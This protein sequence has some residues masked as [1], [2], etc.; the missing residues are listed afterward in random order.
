[1]PMCNQKLSIINQKCTVLFI[2]VF[3][4]AACSK[5]NDNDK[6]S[7]CDIVAF[8]TGGESWQISGNNITISFPKGTAEGSLIPVITVSDKATVNPPSGTAQNFF[9]AGGVQYTVTAEDGK[10]TKTYTAKATVALP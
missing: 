3:A 4:F 6:S 1:M 5:N 2:A 10:T 7:A 8:T 9:T